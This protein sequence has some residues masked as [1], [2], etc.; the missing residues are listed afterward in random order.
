MKKGKPSKTEETG[1]GPE[2]QAPK[3]CHPLLSGSAVSWL[4]LQQ[5][6]RNK[7]ASRQSTP[8]SEMEKFAKL[9]KRKVGLLA[10]L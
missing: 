1:L 3:L 8:V 9:G 6:C 4:P 10:G 5:L 2:P 7:H